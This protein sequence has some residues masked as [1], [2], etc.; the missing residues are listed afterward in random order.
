MPVPL[1]GGELQ[2]SVLHDEDANPIDSVLDG[3]KRRLC[4]D[5]AIAVAAN[6]AV[7]GNIQIQTVETTTPLGGSATFNGT[8][9]DNINYEGFGISATFIG[10][11][12]GTT[13]RVKFQ[14]RD[15]VLAT[16]R[17]AFSV[18]VVVGAG[19]TVNFDQVFSVTRQFGRAQIIN[20][21]ANALATT[22]LISLRKPIA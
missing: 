12:T 2:G 18:D 8:E 15:N 22:E 19:A 10:G 9:H 3:G 21:T 20:T 17:D 11:G 13:I 1:K 5:A 16:F 14:Q 7:D 6:I 4:V